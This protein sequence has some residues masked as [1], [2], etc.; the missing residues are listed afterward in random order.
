[1][2]FEISFEGNEYPAV[3]Y[4]DEELGRDVTVS[5]EA[6]EKELLNEDGV[7]KSSAAE[8]VDNGILFYVPFSTILK[9]EDEIKRFVNE[10][11]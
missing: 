4:Y 10:N 5:T 7:P 11:M 2:R 9:D 1:M 8:K 6:L 3:E